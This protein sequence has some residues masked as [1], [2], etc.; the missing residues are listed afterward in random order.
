MNFRELMDKYKNGTATDE[1][2]QLIEQELEKYEVIEGYYSDRMG[3]DIETSWENEEYL[4]ESVK[5][6]KSVNK[7]FKNLIF[8]SIAIMIALLSSLFFIVSPL[9]DR[10]FY[11][12]IKVTVGE[13]E[14]NAFFDLSVITELN[15]PTSDLSSLIDVNRQGF[16]NYDISFSR[17]NLF[18]DETIYTNAKLKRGEIYNTPA[19]FHEVQ[20]SA[21]GSVVAPDFYDEELV[22]QENETVM[23]H[24]NQLSP[25]SYISSWL[26]FDEALTME[27]LYQLELDYPDITFAW[28]GVRTPANDE[29]HSILGF[30][31]MFGITMVIDDS[32]N[33]EKYPALDIYKF[34]VNPGKLDDGKTRLEPMAYEHH[35]M[36]LLK[37]AVDREE[38]INALEYNHHKHEF[39][40]QA[41]D[42]AKDH[43]VKS[44]G[45]LAYADAGDLIEFVEN[46]PIYHIELDDI[47]VSR[48]NIY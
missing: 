42:Y 40:Q 18:T 20:Y 6:K 8:A 23:D 11:N 31:P 35:Y 1:E 44:Y 41:L 34:L 16:G 15:I 9:V 21:F 24:L 28:V 30:R 36:D 7:K 19:D 37:Y 27:E 32:P 26:T 17:T 48:K 12:P 3:F 10:L 29:V 38:A 4:K 13:T 22:Q 43:G 46:G 45:I 33:V 25:V 39:Y 2:I 14:M 47:S 5:I